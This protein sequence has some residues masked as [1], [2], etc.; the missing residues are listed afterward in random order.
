[1]AKPKS[2]ML[3]ETLELLIPKTLALEPMLGWG[4]AQR[5]QRI[6]QAF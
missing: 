6:M 2:D 1:M 4:L 5:I 3:R